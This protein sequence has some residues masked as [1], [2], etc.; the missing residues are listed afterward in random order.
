MTEEWPFDQ[1][2]NVAAVTTKQVIEDNL[3]I[4]DVHHYEDDHSWAFLCGTTNDTSD[5][6]VIGMG[7]ALKIDPT[8]R[9]IGDLEPGWSASREEVGG[10]W[11]RY[12]SEDDG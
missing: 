5:G 12:K 6:R 7:T 9:E 1:D 2:P 8:L 10:K 3:P 4:L 11:T